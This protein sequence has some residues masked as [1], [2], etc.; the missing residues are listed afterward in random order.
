MAPSL[1]GIVYLPRRQIAH[2]KIMASPSKSPPSPLSLS[3]QSKE[4]DKQETR[5]I[6]EGQEPQAAL[7]AT[8]IFQGVGQSKENMAPRSSQRG[9]G[10]SLNSQRREA[11][12]SAILSATQKTE[13]VLLVASTTNAMQDH[14]C[15]VFDQQAPPT[16]C[17]PMSF[18]S[19]SDTK[20]PA[21]VARG[22][23]IA[24]GQTLAQ[25]PHTIEP[26][27]AQGELKREALA[28]FQKWQTA[29]T[30]RVSEIHVAGDQVQQAPQAQ[31]KLPN[32]RQPGRASGRGPGR[33]GGLNSGRGNP[34]GEV[35][36]RGR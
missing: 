24:A 6:S 15:K 10:R 35:H 14:V 5:S 25:A 20:V 26:D 30:K 8:D 28:A 36:Y 18:S 4:S 32:N 29:I 34:N 2:Q 7:L 31:G 12:L 21:L 22:C 19:N 17:R 13:L 16:G 9:G 23:N 33:T 3:T 27:G 11:D 1:I